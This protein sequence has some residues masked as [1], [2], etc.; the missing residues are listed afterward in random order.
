MSLQPRKQTSLLGTRLIPSFET[1]N[2][3]PLRLFLQPKRVGGCTNLGLPFM[4]TWLS[5][6]RDRTKMHCK[7]MEADLFNAFPDGGTTRMKSVPPRAR[8]SATTRPYSPR[9]QTACTRLPTKLTSQA[10]VS[11]TAR[12]RGQQI[13]I[14]LRHQSPLQGL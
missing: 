13:G 8:Q 1:P 6:R 7:A 9:Q 10:S 14:N 4:K 3:C 12:G 5:Q 2:D 11:L